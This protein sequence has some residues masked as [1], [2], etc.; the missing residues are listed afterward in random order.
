MMVHYILLTLIFLPLIQPEGINRLIPVLG[1]YFYGYYTSF[2][3]SLIAL[4]LFV[5]T[6]MISK[7]NNKI[8]K[9]TVIW[10]TFI[11]FMI[12]MTA[13]REGSI[14]SVINC[15][16][17]SVAIW[18]VFETYKDNIFIPLKVIEIILEIMLCIN[19]VCV[20]VY[21]E[22]MYTNNY[23]GYTDNWFLGYKSSLQYI[24]L[25]YL[26][27][28]AMFYV[29]KLERLNFYFG[30]IVIH[31]QAFLC[32]NLM[33]CI[34]LMVFDFLFFF[35]V[36]KKYMSIGIKT[37]SMLI[38]AANIVIV[39]FFEPLLNFDLVD[40]FLTSIEGKMNN[41]ITRFNMWQIG[42]NAIYEKP[43]LGYGFLT[44]DD[45]ILM[46]DILQPH[47]HNQFL[48]LLLTVGIVGLS[49]FIALLI[50]ILNIAGKNIRF[51]STK[52]LLLSLF[53]LFVCVLVEIF[54][55]SSGYLIWS[56]NFFLLS[57]SE[58]LHKQ[59]TEQKLNKKTIRLI[60]S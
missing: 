12:V 28:I 39:F 5:Y 37:Y 21:P 58:Q 19:L 59:L 11:A 13:L 23:L 14:Y 1:Q 31:V 4:L 55:S 50:H 42:L 7:S 26:T 17:K 43:L 24:V 51:D 38:V 18:L 45:M 36:I 35:N 46:F 2:A 41:M 15:W 27:I 9:T 57:H 56:I 33:L 53:V 20:I 34:G 3:V 52:I 40:V 49:I 29:Y 47:L 25:P 16:Y 10:L 30:M 6:K 48:Q 8:T 32:L 44:G 60:L 54:V 22:G